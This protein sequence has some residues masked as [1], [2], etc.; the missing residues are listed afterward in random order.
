M[1]LLDHHVGHPGRAAIAAD[2]AAAGADAILL[3]LVDDNRHVAEEE[4]ERY[5][6]VVEAAAPEAALAGFGLLAE[7]RARALAAAVPALPLVLGGQPDQSAIDWLAA[8]R[9]GG[10]CRS[11]GAC[12]RDAEGEILCVPQGRPEASH[13]AVPA[14][15]LVDL[16]AYPYSPHQQ[17]PDRVFPVLASR[18]CPFPC[19][20]CETGDQP[21]WAARSVDDVVREIRALHARWG[22][23]SVFFA[24]PHL[25]VDRRWTLDLCEALRRDGP[26]GL[27]WS[28]QVR[29]DAVD[30]ELMRALGE[31][32]CWNVIMGVESLDPDVLAATGKNLDPSTVAPA[33]AAAHAAGVEVILS[34]MIGLPGDSPAGFRRTLQGMIEADP[35]YAQFFVVRLRGGA[36]EGGE[37]VG[38]WEGGDARNFQ[39]R[40]WAASAFHGDAEVVA[41]QR[42][43]YR[44]FY[45]R[46][47]YLKRRLRKLARSERPLSELKRNLAGAALAARLVAGRRR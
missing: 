32:G 11:P 37:F 35:D 44:R 8:V 21:R 3:S 29:P 2:I 40:T 13:A 36:P 45:L 1:A 46:P 19:F 41:L 6:R 30:A 4:L 10:S 22:T 39:G 23:R 24:D 26:S 34:A 7:H 43:A 14:W 5:A 17:T 31:A 28:C 27:V 12:S 16:G 20:F 25:A 38:D 18:G 42:E 47:R 9:Q 33:V 15:D